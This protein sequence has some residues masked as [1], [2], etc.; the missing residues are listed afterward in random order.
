MR[1]HQH[2]AALTTF[3]TDSDDNQSGTTSSYRYLHT[4]L[5][6]CSTRDSCGSSGG[7]VAILAVR[8]HLYDMTSTKR[9]VAVWVVSGRSPELLTYLIPYVAL[10]SLNEGYAHSRHNTDDDYL[11][12]NLR[13]LIEIT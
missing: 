9:E 13:Q 8:V 11:R 7:W 12:S 1:E 6:R 3:N 4:S 10:W 5:L 2:S